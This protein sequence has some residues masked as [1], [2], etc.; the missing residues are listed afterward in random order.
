MGR[1]SLAEGWSCALRPG[2]VDRDLISAQ[3]PAVYG[4]AEEL[5][6]VVKGPLDLPFKLRLIQPLAPIDRISSNR[7]AKSDADL[8]G[9]AGAVGASR[10][11]SRITTSSKSL[12]SPARD[13]QAMESLS[14]AS[15]RDVT[16][17]TLADSSSGRSSLRA[18]NRPMQSDSPAEKGCQQ[19]RS[20]RAVVRQPVRSAPQ[21]GV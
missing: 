9:P 20:G 3:R 14:A 18:Q 8:A 6:D 7:V 10:G 21:H 1:G 11:C 19:K 17:S 13:S 4:R 16:G 5:D 2:E 15:S 12:I